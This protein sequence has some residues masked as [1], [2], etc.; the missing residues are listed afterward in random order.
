[1]L[2]LPVLAISATTQ[3]HASGPTELKSRVV[4]ASVLKQG[5]ALVVR[6][7]DVPSG[8]GTFKLDALPDA[9]D[10]SFWYGSPDGVDV[11]DVTT[12]LRFKTKP[13]KASTIAE[14]LNANLNHRI[15]FYETE[16]NWTVRGN[17]TK[18]KE[19]YGVLV[20]VPQSNNYG[21]VVGG[22]TFRLDNGDLY[23][24]GAITR[25][26][27][28]G[29]KTT[30]NQG[31]PDEEIDFQV[32]AK[33]GGRV[34]FATLE[35]DAAWTDSYLV[36][37]STDSKAEVVSKAQ[38]A[39]GGLKMAN[40]EVQVV[41]G[42]PTLPERVK[43]DLAAGFG[44]LTAYLNNQQENYR[45][46]RMVNRD[47]YVFIP[48]YFGQGSGFGQ[49]A[50]FAR[51]MA[52][53]R[54]FGGGGFGMQ[55]AGEIDE[56]SPVFGNQPRTTTATEKVEDLYGFPL[57]HVDLEPGDRLSRVM[58]RVES[59]YERLYRWNIVHDIQ[60]PYVQ[61]REES[62]VE[63]ILQVKNTSEL[64]WPSG[65]AMIVENNVP[66]GQVTMNF[67]PVGKSCELGL[68]EV[69]DIPVHQTVRELSRTNVEVRGNRLSEV[70][71]EATLVVENT[72]K[73]DL[74]YE[75]S[76]QVSGKVVDGNGAQ[77]EQLGTSS[78][79]NPESHM[80]WKFTLKAGETK[81]FTVKF[82]TNV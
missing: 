51:D 2:I 3:S 10:G 76:Y 18:L 23:S 26:D 1:M 42:S 4:S 20:D 81:Q 60:S 77:V 16:S 5:L 27:T 72:R 38:L 14:L 32:E 52:G 19:V 11:N 6:E 58:F 49:S 46:F 36:T 33:H 41:S 78:V 55:S 24:P 7:V 9:L 13:V 80:T 67:T 48:T 66:L 50:M 25:L 63:K 79:F 39:V 82:K 12:K 30:V 65:S 64:P 68:G 21:G 29:L 70:T 44:S 40:T 69:T 8:R 34:D 54:G 47:P 73:E 59:P 53:G 75:V 28:K 57:G 35:P 31:Y 43:Y 37:L 22:Y 61:Q 71:S 17:E 45:R 15:H 56:P 74:P 62:M